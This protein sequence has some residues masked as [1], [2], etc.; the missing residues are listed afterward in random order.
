MNNSQLH[1][2]QLFFNDFQFLIGLLGFNRIQA[3][4]DAVAVDPGFDSNL[5]P[6]RLTFHT[7]EVEE[8]FE[9]LKFSS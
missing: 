7:E 5:E 8:G 4:N 9:N 1:F 6:T 3:Q 2:G